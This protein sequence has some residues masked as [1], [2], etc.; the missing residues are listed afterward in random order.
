M[1]G[2]A[3]V[4]RCLSAEADRDLKARDGCRARPQLL[5]CGAAGEKVMPSKS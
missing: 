5:E 4:E 2:K 1:A 3:E